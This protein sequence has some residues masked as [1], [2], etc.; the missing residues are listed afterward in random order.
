M[1]LGNL[2]ENLII[3]IVVGLLC[4]SI[5]YFA[6]TFSNKQTIELLTPTIKEALARETTKIENKIT[7]DIKVEIDKLKKSDSLNININQ[8]P[9]TE[10]KPK[11]KITIKKD[12]AAPPPKEKKRSW[13]GRLF[14][15]K[16]DN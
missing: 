9:Q 2:S 12:S 10:Q 3:T 14:K 8:N 15:G 16:K 11:N 13:L 4:G 6:S 7:H 1:K 5:G